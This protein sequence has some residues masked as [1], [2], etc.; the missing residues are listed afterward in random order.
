MSPLPILRNLPTFPTSCSERYTAA[1][2]SGVRNAGQI[3]DG[4][5]HAT[6]GETAEGAAS[7]FQNPASEG[8]ANL[9][10]SDYACFKT[11]KDLV[12]PWAAP[13]YN[14]RGFHVEIVGFS[15]WSHDEWMK[16]ERR[17]Q[18]A[19]YRM[20]LRCKWYSI[21][22]VFRT[23]EELKEG[24]HG[25]TTHANISIAFRQTNHTD[26]GP[27]FPV[28]YYMECLKWYSEH[29]AAPKNLT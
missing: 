4:I 8:S 16:V 20:A 22:V 11:V 14:T 24:L 18:H 25:I 6:E 5:I 29:M 23:A 28:S 9:V 3:T 26:P 27:N 7:W 10:V 17:I 19:A 15:D 12:I 21:P 2:N 13:P 1:H